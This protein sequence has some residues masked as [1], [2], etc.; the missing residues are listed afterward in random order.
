MIK[1]SA[2]GVYIALSSAVKAKAR[3]IGNVYN[4]YVAT[5]QDK[6]QP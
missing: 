4:K 3:V 2:A 5:V 1:K 6:C